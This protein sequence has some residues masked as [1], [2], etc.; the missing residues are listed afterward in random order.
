MT[1]NRAGEIQ[2]KDTG[3]D[4]IRPCEGLNRD[5][6][7]CFCSEKTVL[8][9]QNFNSKVIS[10]MQNYDVV[11]CD[12]CGFTYADNIP[13]QSDFNNYYATMSKYEFNYKDGFIS[14]DY[15]EYFTKVADF[16]IPHVKDKSARILDIGCSTGGLL[17]VLKNKG[18]S[19]L[20]GIDPSPQ[21]ARITRDING[22]EA[23]ANTI[24]NFEPSGKFDLISLSAVLEHLVDFGNSMR[25][26]WSLLKDQGLLFLEVPDVERFSL[27]ITSPFQ[28]FSIEHINYFSKYSIKNLLSRFSFKTIEVHQSKHKLSQ[29]TEVDIFCLSQKINEHSYEI[30]R[31]DFSESSIRDYIVQSDRDDLELKQVIGEKL[32]KKNKVI[33][34]GVGTH[35][36]RLI[37]SGLDSSKILYFVDS[38][39]RYLGKKINGIEIK[40]PSDIKEQKIPILISTHSYQEEITYQIRKVLKLSNEIITLY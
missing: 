27:Y 4:E 12:N 26:I 39:T 17:S 5:C 11:V 28:Q 7:I 36:L 23:T 8:Y 19:N 33:V 10:L 34:W 1:N 38:N 6:P 31:D 40:S 15:I 3:N 22:I 35:T 16:I 30:I 21:C 13:S 37:G 20:V 9:K 32:W 14:N 29:T 25:K 24:S 2:V 18:Y